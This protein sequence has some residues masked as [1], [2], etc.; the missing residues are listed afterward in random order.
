MWQGESRLRLWQ[1]LASGLEEA[2]LSR[3]RGC[4]AVSQ[5]QAEQLGRDVQAVMAVREHTTTPT[6]ER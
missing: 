4:K 5:Q 1:G 2:L 3:V 6:Y